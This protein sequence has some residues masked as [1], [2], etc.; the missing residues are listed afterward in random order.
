MSPKGILGSSVMEM[1]L[2]IVGGDTKEATSGTPLVVWYR[3]VD[4]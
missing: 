2:L 1:H 3:D 4:F